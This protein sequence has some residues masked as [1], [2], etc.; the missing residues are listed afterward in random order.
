ME[1]IQNVRPTSVKLTHSVTGKVGW[2]IRVEHDDPG[3]VIAKLDNLNTM[4]KEKF[5]DDSA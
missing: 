3:T 2:E 5:E 1:T 4:L